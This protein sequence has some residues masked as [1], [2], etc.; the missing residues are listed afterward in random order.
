MSIAMSSSHLEC[1]KKH[2]QE[3]LEWRQTDARIAQES[4]FARRAGRRHTEAARP[5]RV[6]PA[7]RCRAAKEVRPVTD[8]L[9]RSTPPARARGEAPPPAARSWHPSDRL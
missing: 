4:A 2:T 3:R 7:G 5:R 6:N 1:C 9:R 8:T